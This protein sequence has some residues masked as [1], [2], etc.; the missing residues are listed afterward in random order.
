LF[1]VGKK[2]LPHAPSIITG[3]ATVFINNRPAA[4]VGDSILQCTRIASGSFD[5]FIGV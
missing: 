2:C 3:S 4:R 5:V 1:K